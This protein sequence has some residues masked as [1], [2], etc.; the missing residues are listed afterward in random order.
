M[1]DKN[2]AHQRKLKPNE[3]LVCIDLPGQEHDIP[4]HSFAKV[5][6]V[7]VLLRKWRDVVFDLNTGSGAT[8]TVESTQDWIYDFKAKKR[9]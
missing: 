2:L 4:C 1:S 6:D 7:Y 9:D 5:T 8:Y 3:H